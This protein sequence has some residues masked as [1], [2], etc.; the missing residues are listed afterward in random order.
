MKKKINRNSNISHL[1][2]SLK[3]TMSKRNEG[4]GRMFR[5]ECRLHVDIRK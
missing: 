3:D 5:V 1:S 2:L 4:G